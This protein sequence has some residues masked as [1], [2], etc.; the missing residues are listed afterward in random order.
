MYHTKIKVGSMRLSDFINKYQD[1]EKFMAYCRE[2]K[3]YKSRW[4][5]PPL[6]FNANEFL[7]DFHYIYLFGV[8]VIYD[9][10]T[11]KSADT[12]EKIRDITTQTLKEVKNKLA[13]ELLALEVKYPGSIS[14]ASGGCHL[15][16]HCK[17]TDNHPCVYP[18]KMRYSLDSF[19]FDLTAITSELLQIEL[20]WSKDSLPEYYTLIHALLTNN[21]HENILENFKL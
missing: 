4:S 14:L 17:R 8:Q 13:N 5:C 6:Q 1:Q 15:C 16:E 11:I 2:C 21:F 9:A 7:Q 12:P 20:K 19:G 18:E 10:E 3:N